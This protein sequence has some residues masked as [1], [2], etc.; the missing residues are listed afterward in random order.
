M[1]KIRSLANK[2]YKIC[3]NCVMDTSDSK[4]TFNDNGMCDHCE[5]FYNNIKSL[6][7][8]ESESKAKIEIMAK[9]IKKNGNNNDFDCIIGLSGGLDS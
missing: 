7:E 1:S 5:N 3:S 6:L 4:I 2:K 8:T 9:K